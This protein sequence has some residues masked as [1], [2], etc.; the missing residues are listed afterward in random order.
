[1]RSIRA[2]SV[3]RLREAKS[4]VDHHGTLF[5]KKARD[6]SFFDPAWFLPWI[7]HI[8]FVHL[9][10]I[11]LFKYKF[12][13]KG[14]SL[15]TKTTG[16]LVL[17]PTNFYAARVARYVG[18]LCS[19][20][21]SPSS[22][23]TH[24]SYLKCA[25]DLL[26]VVKDCETCAATRLRLLCVSYEDVPTWVMALACS[27]SGWLHVHKKVNS[28]LGGG[29]EGICRYSGYTHLFFWSFTVHPSMGQK[30]IGVS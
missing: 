11:K 12:F 13:R 2:G 28:V 25:K 19:V 29:V 26:F 5:W 30:A 27:F 8:M 23:P 1:M 9:F 22:S 7:T 21:V 17:L 16:T 15:G 20:T 24:L 14:N 6:K 4:S 10:V 18:V 3:E